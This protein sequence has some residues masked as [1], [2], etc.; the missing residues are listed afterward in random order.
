MTKGDA[1]MRENLK[2]AR[3]ANGMT[4]QAM[5]DDRIQGTENT[6]CINCGRIVSKTWN[7]CPKCGQRIM[8]I[9]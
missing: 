5:A 9:L 2:A 7:Y 8:K 1:G 3:K 6:Q 4:Q